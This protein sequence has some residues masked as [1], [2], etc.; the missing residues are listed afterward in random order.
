M[1]KIN[2]NSVFSN[3][4]IFLGNKTSCKI[5]KISDLHSDTSQK[6]SYAFRDNNGYFDNT[7][8]IQLDLKDCMIGIFDLIF[9]T[10]IIILK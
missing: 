1:D 7:L 8:Q 6:M 10:T 4:L 9:L 2:L 3:N 5:P